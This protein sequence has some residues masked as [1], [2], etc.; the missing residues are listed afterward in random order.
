M[1]HED[2]AFGETVYIKAKKERE[3]NW[4]SYFS[5]WSGTLWIDDNWYLEW[6][7]T[8][9]ELNELREKAEKNFTPVVWQEYE[10]SDDWIDWKIFKFYWFYVIGCYFDYFKRIRKI[11]KKVTIEVKKEHE[12]KVKDFISSLQ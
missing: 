7:I 8:E 4:Y 1:K 3:C 10:F 6:A 2:I 9:K 12:Q 5:T 11:T